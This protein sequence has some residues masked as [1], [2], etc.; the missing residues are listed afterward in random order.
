MK[1]ELRVNEICNSKDFIKELEE[2]EYI[3]R[4]TYL[5][6]AKVYEEISIRNELISESDKFIKSLLE[7]HYVYL[8]TIVIIL[9]E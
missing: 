1:L 2:K 4:E 7:I 9:L 8:S 5:I 6:K 3:D